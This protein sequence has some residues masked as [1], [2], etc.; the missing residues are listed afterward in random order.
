MEAIYV[1]P[2]HILLRSQFCCIGFSSQMILTVACVMETKKI[3]YA[4]S[5]ESEKFF[6]SENCHFFL[7]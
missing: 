5:V 4:G 6:S 3:L 1:M 7:M 2:G